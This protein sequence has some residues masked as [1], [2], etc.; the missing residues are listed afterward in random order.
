VLSFGFSI[1]TP[2]SYYSIIQWAFINSPLSVV[3]VPYFLRYRNRIEFGCKLDSISHDNPLE[4]FQDHPFSQKKEDLIY[5]LHKKR[6]MEKNTII[7]P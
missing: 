4:L 3:I 2:Q 7:I 6:Y 1:L 5:F